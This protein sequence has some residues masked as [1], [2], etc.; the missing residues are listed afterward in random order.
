MKASGYL[1]PAA[2][3]LALCLGLFF[4]CQK[5]PLTDT[6]PE[7]GV[8]MA[9]PQQVGEFS[10]TTTAPSLA[11]RNVLPKDTEMVR[12][13]Y[14]DPGGDRI[15]AS[16]VLSGGAKQSIH[17]PEVCL[18]GQ[19]WSVLSAETL[20]I[21]PLIGKR[22]RVMDLRLVTEIQTGPGERRNLEAHYFYWFIGKDMVTPFHYVRLFHNSWDRVFRRVNH[23]WAYAAVM[24]EVT[25]GFAPGGK[26]GP[27]T[28]RMLKEFTAQLA[29][30]FLRRE[31]LSPGE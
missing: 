27:Q 4:L 31:A 9:L 11:E 26:D 19:G 20:V 24:S 7:A 5:T 17:R 22:F 6:V 18:P 10:G 2:A 1:A 16:I 12:M 15:V 21:D 23:R 28:V 14:A 3:F 8:I 30:R 29:P 25:S 13:V